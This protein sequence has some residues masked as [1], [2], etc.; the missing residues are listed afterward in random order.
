MSW[1]SPTNKNNVP[2]CIRLLDKWDEYRLGP[3]DDEARSCAPDYFRCTGSNCPHFVFFLQSKDPAD[4][5]A[6][7]IAGGYPNR[8]YCDKVG[9]DRHWN[10]PAKTPR[11]WVTNDNDD[12]S[13]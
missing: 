7:E 11:R 9:P 13:F 1:K 3:V 4:E 8:G 5:A 10:D 12:V 6:D 2:V